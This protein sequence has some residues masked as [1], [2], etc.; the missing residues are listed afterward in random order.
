MKSIGTGN[1]LIED[2]YPSKVLNPDN[3]GLAKLLKN[4]FGTR[5]VSNIDN[6]ILRRHRITVILEGC[7]FLAIFS[8][9]FS[10]IQSN[11]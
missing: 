6:L 5:L 4:V 10:F 2:L 11:I 7:F 3:V 8:R 9:E 1:W